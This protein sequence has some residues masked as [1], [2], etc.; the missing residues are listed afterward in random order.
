[1]GEEDHLRIMAMKKAEAINDVFDRLKSAI[2]V[3]EKLI[4][5]G[6]AKSPD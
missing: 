3:V 4:P 2:D 5:G 1:V 6:C